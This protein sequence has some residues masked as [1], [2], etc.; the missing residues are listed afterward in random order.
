MVAIRTRRD[1][2]VLRK[3]YPTVPPRVEY[4]LTPLG[5]EAA[6]LAVTI[7]EWALSHVGQIL[8]AREAFA[9]AASAEPRPLG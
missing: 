5:N 6:L 8:A 3:V 1:G 7:G 9:A 4:G 2:L